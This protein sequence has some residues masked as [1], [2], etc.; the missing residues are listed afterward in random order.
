V[1]L[2]IGAKGAKGKEAGQEVWCACPLCMEMI[3]KIITYDGGREANI[4]WDWVYEIKPP[5]PPNFAKRFKSSQAVM[6]AIQKA[7]SESRSD[8]D[9]CDGSPPLGTESD[10]KACQIL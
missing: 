1:R 5:L 8:G 10:S 4:Y 2:N 7:R 3:T 6:D 9:G